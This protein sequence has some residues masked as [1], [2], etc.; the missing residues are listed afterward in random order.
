MHLWTFLAI[1]IALSASIIGL[2]RKWQIKPIHYQVWLLA[3]LA[4]G[5]ATLTGIT[6]VW[7]TVGS[8]LAVG[9][10]IAICY[11][12]TLVMILYFFFRDPDRQVQLDERQLVSP[13]DGTIVYIKQIED[14]RFP[15]AV[16]GRKTIPLSEFVDADFVPERGTQIGIA[17]NFLNVHVNRSPI[18]GTVKLVKRIPGKFTSL[19]EI[20]ALLENERTL[21]VVENDRIALGIVLIASRLVRRIVSYVMP[22]EVI[23]QGQ[24]IGA[25]RFGSQVDLLIPEVPGMEIIAKV[26]DDVM[27]GESVLV[28]LPAELQPIQ[29][30][31]SD[32]IEYSAAGLQHACCE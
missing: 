29:A 25:I 1:V 23:E 28:S 22:G 11:G 16:K 9:A 14:A 21:M 12:L 5:A 27:A 7:P 10:S 4:I 32:Q 8:W 13:A 2:G 3:M 30:I 6:H 24:R 15:F 20:A 26:G 19:R 17:M 18:K 31:D